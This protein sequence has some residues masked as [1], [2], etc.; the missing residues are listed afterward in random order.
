MPPGKE[1]QG[2]ESEKRGCGQKNR[3]EGSPL[4]WGS[5]LSLPGAY[6]SGVADS[7]DRGER[8]LEVV[9]SRK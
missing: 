4:P 7:G 6:L 9:G 1:A 8:R 5:R 2:G 3:G